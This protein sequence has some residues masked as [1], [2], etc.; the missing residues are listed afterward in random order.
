MRAIVEAVGDRA[1][2]VALTVRMNPEDIAAMVEAVRPTI[3]HLCQLA[4]D[5]T[6]VT[7]SR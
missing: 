4:S 5:I 6:P 1:R 3:L 2:C 7:A